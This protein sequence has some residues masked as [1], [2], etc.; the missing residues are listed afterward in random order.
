MAPLSRSR[1][2]AALE[3]AGAATLVTVVA[4]S[5]STNDD[6]RAAAHAGAP[7]GAA[8]LAEHQ[9]SGRGRRGRSWHA[10]PGESICL[11]L[12]LRPALSPDRLA[13]L[14][15]VAGLA[16]ARVVDRAL[17]R[18]GAAAIKWPND[19]LVRGGK[20]AGILI[21]SSL[22]AAESPL[23][24]V[25]VG[26]N[27]HTR[28]FP[29]DPSYAQPPTSLALAGAAELDRDHLAAELIA[30]LRQHV[31]GYVRDGLGALRSELAR[32]DALF[33]RTV[34]AAGLVGVARGFDGEGALLI[35]AA[36]QRHAIRSGSV[37]LVGS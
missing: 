28:L 30:S 25:G 17:D 37:R 9:H 31:D 11:S 29:A 12:V 26:L 20:I 32:R 23:C 15:L 14:S 13:P 22:S 35:E 5:G 19:V 16:V 10:P 6:A 36:G 2:A 21:E 27:V 34:T 4:E 3:A 7:H 33:G 24:I 18:A 8:F 1:I